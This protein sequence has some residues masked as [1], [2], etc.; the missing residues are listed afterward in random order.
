MEEMMMM[1]LRDMIAEYL[2]SVPT[3]EG[4]AKEARSLIAEIRRAKLVLMTTQHRPE[5][6]RSHAT[7]SISRQLVIEAQEAVQRARE[8][9]KML[10]AQRHV[11]AKREEL[12]KFLLESETNTRKPIRKLLIGFGVAAVLSS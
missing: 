4:Q 10:I 3:V 11:G 12:T 7:Q 9:K 8:L 5:I 1:N 2:Q 6:K